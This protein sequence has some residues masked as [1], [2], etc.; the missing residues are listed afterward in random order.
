MGRD[1]RQRQKTAAKKKA[2]REKRKAER[3]ASSSPSDFYGTSRHQVRAAP[4]HACFMTAQLFEIGI[5]HVVIARRLPSGL[6]AVG[7][8]MVDAYCLGVKGAGFEMASPI[9]FER[10]KERMSQGG[11]PDVALKAVPPAYARKLIESSLAYASKLG[12][13]PDPDYADAA[14]IFGDINPGECTEAFVFGK[15]GKPFYV[16][17]PHDSEH[18]RAAVLASLRAR[19]GEGNYDFLVNVD[20]NLPP[21]FGE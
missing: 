3:G 8:F 5:G 21:D 6:I 20:E 19:C 17:G 2:R 14:V 12:L 13:S 11:D 18:F 7:F 1:P 10:M 16:S 9:T 15:D 4:I